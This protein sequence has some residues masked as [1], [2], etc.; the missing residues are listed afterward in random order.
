LSV[1]ALQFPCGHR[2]VAAVI[3]GVLLPERVVHNVAAF[4]DVIPADFRPR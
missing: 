3:P 1:V 4:R 2:S